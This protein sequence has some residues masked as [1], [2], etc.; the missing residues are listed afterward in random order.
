MATHPEA[1][2]PLPGDLCSNLGSR[3]RAALPLLTFLI[4]GSPSFSEEASR[5]EKAIMRSAEARAV[6]LRNELGL[7]HR[8]SFMALSAIKDELGTVH[9]RIHQLY[10]G[11]KIAGGDTILHG[12][13]EAF[14]LTDPSSFTGFFFKDINISTIP[15][16]DTKEAIAIACQSMGIIKALSHEPNCELLI[17]PLIGNIF[18]GKGQAAPADVDA[19]Q[20]KRQ[21]VGY[22]LVY[23]VKLITENVLDGFREQLYT[24]DAHSGQVLA[25]RSDLKTSHRKKG[26]GYSQH[27]GCVPLDTSQGEDNRFEM[28]DMTR[29]QGG[30]ATYNLNHDASQ[31]NGKGDI[32]TDADNTWG[33]GQNYTG[34]SSTSDNGQTAAVDAHYALQVT[35]DFLRHI[36]DRNGLDGK[37]RAV[38]NRVHAGKQAPMAFWSDTSFSVTFGDGDPEKGIKVPTSVDI[39][40]HELAH[41][42]C[43]CTAKLEYKGE[44]G[45]LNEA[46]SDITGAMVEF[47]VRGGGFEAQAKKIPDS[48]GNFEIGEQVASQPLRYMY[49]PSKDGKSPDEWGP[50]LEQMDVHSAAGPA[51]RMFYFLAQGAERMGEK[52]TRRLP[53]GMAGLGN[54]KAFRI[55][56]RALNLYMT[57]STNYAGARQALIQSAQDLYGKE[58]A[59]EAAVWNAFA[60]IHVGKPWID[61]TPTPQ[62][63]PSPKPGSIPGKKP[64]IS[65]GE[66][67]PGSGPG[68]GPKGW[69][70][71]GIESGTGG[72][73][74]TWPKGGTS[75]EPDSMPSNGS[76]EAPPWEPQED[77]WG[78]PGKWSSPFSNSGIHLKQ[79][80]EEGPEFDLSEDPTPNAHQRPAPLPSTVCPEP[81]TDPSKTQ[82]TKPEAEDLL[83]EVATKDKRCVDIK[84]KT[85]TGIPISLS[86]HKG[87]IIVLNICATWSP[88]ARQDAKELDTLH[89]QHKSKELVCVTCL[90]DGAQKSA[91]ADWASK[92]KITMPVMVDS[93]GKKGPADTFYYS[94]TNKYPTYVII[95]REFKVQE[96]I[97]GPF[98]KVRESAIKA[99]AKSATARD[100]KAISLAPSVKDTIKSTPLP[101]QKK[102]LQNPL[103]TVRLKADFTFLSTGKCQDRSIGSTGAQKAADHIAEAFKTMGLKPLKQVDANQP[104]P[105]HLPWNYNKNTVYN[106]GG[107]F[108]STNPK[109]GNEYILITT[110]YDHTPRKGASTAKAPSAAPIAGLLQIA[111]SLKSA[112]LGRSIVFIAFAGTYEGAMGSRALLCSCPLPLPAIRGAIHLYC[113]IN[114]MGVLQSS[115]QNSDHAS[116][117]EKGIPSLIINTGN[118]TERH[119]I[120]TNQSENSDS[121]PEENLLRQIQ[122]MTQAIQDIALGVSLDNQDIVRPGKIIETNTKQEIT[123]PV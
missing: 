10:Q 9:A 71:G 40:A 65:G 1:K 103:D 66:S 21:I 117:S 105:F 62:P 64:P 86:E 45:G 23:K 15:S 68:C 95:N 57:S 112:K 18:S 108:Q 76:N 73:T 80:A 7:N 22:R 121:S 30:N 52:S 99:L 118:N 16:L 83:P 69:P 90:A 75:G 14:S 24:I 123:A 35:W 41:G 110:S 55:W 32:V 119:Y 56:Y 114:G 12:T 33:D 91:A 77:Q 87:K 6:A 122:T 111:N 38:S 53:K 17:E 89:Q 54:D 96:I 8:H 34:A 29:G 113:P 101:P 42:L 60:A 120:P 104:S 50:E 85:S 19:T 82:P 20:I 43:G 48:D 79:D 51:N 109:L 116:F 93:A 2:R 98:T 92:H 107:M 102:A 67:L 72:G 58:S 115:Q 5:R 63:E 49:K 11:L 61:I 46:N 70:S 78:L 97:T 37:G 36:L 28:R 47:Y 3:H 59:E 44:S 25:A 84:G 106:I 26:M 94:A 88:Q 100:S 74:N 31:G 13:D 81:E 4:A 39:A 27:N